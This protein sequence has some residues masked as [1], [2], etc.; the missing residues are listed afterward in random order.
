[1]A[2]GYDCEL[3]SKLDNAA[4]QLADT[5]TKWMR[6]TFYAPY[7]KFCLSEHE[8]KEWRV[9]VKASL[10][11]I[12]AIRAHIASA[13]ANDDLMWRLYRDA[14]QAGIVRK[15]L[16]FDAGIGSFSKQ[17]E[18]DLAALDRLAALSE[19]LAEAGWK[20]EAE[21]KKKEREAKAPAGDGAEA[22]A[23]PEKHP[24]GR[25]KGPAQPL[26]GPLIRLAA[27]SF[28]LI[29]GRWPGRSH[30]HKSPFISFLIQS[31]ENI[32]KEIRPP[33]PSTTAVANIVREWKNRSSVYQQGEN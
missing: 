33:H 25:P 31:I 27:D 3:K 26:I 15:S 2:R 30:S 9:R 19:R 4:L 29:T 16:M 5:F 18:E 32:P 8:Y 13:V 21:K 24:G 28:Y 17:L 11:K 12:P 14:E 6:S 10:G 1:M 20:E 23:Q 7:G 22:G